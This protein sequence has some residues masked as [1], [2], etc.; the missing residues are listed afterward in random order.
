MAAGDGERAQHAALDGR[1][2]DRDLVEGKLH[3]SADQVVEGRSVAA[4]VHRQPFQAQ[5]RLH[6]LAE[7]MVGGALARRGH[8]Q[9]ARFA[10]GKLDE[11]LQI[12]GRH[13]RMHLEHQ[14][15]HRDRGDRDKIPLPIIGLA[16]GDLGCEQHGAVGA[17]EQGVA[18]GF[19]FR[20]RLAGDQATGA[21][22]VLDDE[23]LAELRLEPVGDD[24][25]RAVD[26]AAC[27]IGDDQA[28][29]PRRPLLGIG[30]RAQRSR[31]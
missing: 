26:I 30:R 11:F 27:R 18:V 20:E 19:G 29:L 7:Q 14:R 22:L 15:C 25:R 9:L 6:Q 3:L 4:V 12:L 24:A 31:K 10:A 16:L 13:R 5:R 28:Y 2:S 23:R 8:R 17:D 1:Q 21:S